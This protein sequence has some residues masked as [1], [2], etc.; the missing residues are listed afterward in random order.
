M[1][2]AGTPNLTNVHQ[3]LQAASLATKEE[4][5][6]SKNFSTRLPIEAKEVAQEICERHGTTLGE[7][8]RQCVLGLVRDYRE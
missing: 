5:A 8:L 1:S 4:N 7:F 3:A 6:P 2:D